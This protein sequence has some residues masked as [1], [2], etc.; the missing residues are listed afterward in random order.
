MREKVRRKIMGNWLYSIYRRM[1]YIRYLKKVRKI[2]RKELSLELEQ[3]QQEARLTMKQQN[4]LERQLDKEKQKRIKQE[5]IQ[6][7]KRIKA[8][9]RTKVINDR[10]AE[11]EKRRAE[12]EELKKEKEAVRQRLKVKTV[13]DKQL[14]LDQKKQAKLFKELRKKRK[15]KLRPYIVKRR[16]RAFFRGL[17]SIN[18]QSL[19]DWSVWSTELVANKNDRNRFLKIFFNSLFMFMLSYLIIY[20]IGEFIT[21]WVATTFDYKVILF[22][23]KIYYSIDSD[24][25]TADSVKILYS[26]LPFTG[27]IIGVVGIIIFSSLR[28]EN[29]YFKLF[30]LWSFVHGIVMFFGSILMGTLLNQG[31]GWV[32]AYL[33]YKDTGKMIF[34]IIS[35]FALFIAGTSITRSF[36]ISGNAY[37]N[38][39]KHENRKFLFVSQVLLPAIIGT[40]IM[41]LLKIPTDD[42]FSTN[43]EYIFEISKISTILLIILPVGLTFKSMGDVYFDEDGR[44]VKFAWPFLLITLAIFILHFFVLAPG[45]VYN[46]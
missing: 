2:R 42:Y 16:F 8:E 43:E 17:R 6:E 27:L 23:Y 14:E 38:F 18:K 4:R 21:V 5:A 7:R 33:Y 28:N 3:E 46:P 19:K 36:L 1:R 10:I 37:F 24:Q 20:I 11:K 45:V 9:M 35:I 22:P 25:W 30:F 26:I 41:A 32:I 31:F 34:S 39:V 12:Q 40:T 29:G 13:Q 44:K 15:R